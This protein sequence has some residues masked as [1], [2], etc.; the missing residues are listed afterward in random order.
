MSLLQAVNGNY[1]GFGNLTADTA[2]IDKVSTDSLTV[3]TLKIEGAVFVPVP[4]FVD[5]TSYVVQ[6]NDYIIIGTQYDDFSLTLPDP[7]ASV[8]RSLIV[9]SNTG[10]YVY[11]TEDNVAAPGNSAEDGYITDLIVSDDYEAWAEIISNGTYWVITTGYDQ[12]YW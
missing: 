10:Y 3:D 7:A 8:G 2:F 5:E 9:R 1:G 6:D 12:N 11:S 4:K